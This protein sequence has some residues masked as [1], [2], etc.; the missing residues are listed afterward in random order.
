VIKINK[1]H[2]ILVGNI[3]CAFKSREIL[4]KN[5]IKS[6]ILRRH[7]SNFG[8]GYAIYAP[9][10]TDKAVKLLVNFN[11]KILGRFPKEG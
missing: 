8:C 2:Y 1:D 5:N 6:H 3:T 9:D 10:N 4:N 7:S 11:I